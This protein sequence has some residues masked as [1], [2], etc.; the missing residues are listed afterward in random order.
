[1]SAETSTFRASRLG[2]SFDL[3]AAY[4]GHGGFFLERE[5]IGVAASPGIEI[6]AERGDEANIREL[7]VH[8]MGMLRSLGKDPS[9]L[10][11]GAVGF[12]RSAG[13]T[14]QVPAA[15]VRRH[16]DEATW[17]LQL[18]PGDARPAPLATAVRGGSPRK[19]FADVEMR[20]LPSPDVYADA[21]ARA[22]SE[23]RDGAVRKVVL[24]R[25]IA[26]DA[27]HEL[28]PRRLLHH[29]RAVEPHAFSFAV[30]AA[31][32]RGV[33]ASLVGASPELLVSR[34][35]LEIRSNPLAGSAS[36]SGDPEEDRENA[37]A[38]ADSAKDHEEHAIVVDAMAE[39]LG[40]FCQEL[41]WDPVPVLHE[42]ANVWH[43][44]TRF[45]GILREGPP[46]VLELVAALHPTPAVCGEP[47]AEALGLIGELE[48]FDRGRYA[49]AV[50]WID[51]V[52]DGEW[53]IALRCA[54]LE[55][56]RATLYA[57]AGIVADSVPQREVDETDRKFR[58]FLDAL[59]WG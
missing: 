55:S 19:A 28:D 22:V 58:A 26:V 54:E 41:A 31:G 23:I 13:A 42:T 16:D 32:E 36:R 29:L 3:L 25:T 17:Q 43:L 56:E 24:A 11:V 37:R 39:T 18:I 35:G 15:S 57:G 7:D 33:R 8:V 4:P 46:S 2:R 10:A 6:A 47:R 48:A 49:G 21:V 45:H 59:R 20:E 40:P 1:M 38:L 53:V 44:S 51:A 30:P 5:G 9:P 34:R 52:G 14:L 27:G 12:D 50:G